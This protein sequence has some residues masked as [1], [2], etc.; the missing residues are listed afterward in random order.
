MTASPVGR[1]SDILEYLVSRFPRA[2]QHILDSHHFESRLDMLV[3]TVSLGRHA[4]NS[5]PTGLNLD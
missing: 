4:I 1:D 3:N 2:E 5:Y